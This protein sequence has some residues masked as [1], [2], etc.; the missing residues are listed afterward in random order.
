MGK[1]STSKSEAKRKA[2]LGAAEKGELNESPAPK[3]PEEVKP[4]SERE[5]NQEAKK[6]VAD[7]KVNGVAK[8][9]KTGFGK[10]EVDV[11]RGEEYI[12][13]FSKEVHGEDW[14]KLAEEFV[15]K[16][17]KGQ[18]SLVPPVA[19][20]FV[21]WREERK[22]DAGISLGY[23]EKRQRFSSKREAVFFNNE[24]KGVIKV[25]R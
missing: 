11:V 13:T 1:K 15:A 17:S 12:R 3:S 23:F 16:D 24:V 22:S 9:E 21:E 18:R 4:K 10:E 19:E 25:A 7:E 20:V 14:K 8:P 6:K 5:L 2:V